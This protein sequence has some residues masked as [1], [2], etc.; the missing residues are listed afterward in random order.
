VPHHPDTI[1]II[2]HAEKPPSGGPP[3]PHLTDTGRARAAA[4]VRYPFPPLAAI[5]AAKTSLES[6]RPV[7]TVTPIAA[8]RRLLPVRADVKDKEFP[9]LVPQVLSRDFDGKDILICWHHGEIPDLARALGAAVPASYR[10]PCGVFDRVWVLTYAADGTVTR[11]D[12]PQHLL[13]GDS[14]T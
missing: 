5:F 2:R 14:P 13:P 10:W 7:E 3:D 6:A 11:E 4:L 8:D 1:F 9:Q 12:R